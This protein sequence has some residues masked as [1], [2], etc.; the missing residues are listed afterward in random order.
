MEYSV[1]LH[2][3]EEGGYWA[4]VPALSGCF[5]QGETVEQ[6]MRNIRSAIVS[7]LAALTEDHR[8]I[9]QEGGILFARVAVA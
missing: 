2:E 9:P 4:E 7:H 6:A 3:A 1:V 8:P 5:S